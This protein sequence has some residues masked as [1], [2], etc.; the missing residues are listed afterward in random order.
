MES[1]YKHIPQRCEPDD[2]RRCQSAGPHGQCAF[3]SV[4]G[5][6]RC[7][8]HLGGTRTEN[9]VSGRT[10]ELFNIKSIEVI[11]QLQ[12]FKNHPDSKKLTT[13]LA[14]LRVLLENT[15]NQC[16]SSFDLLTH[17]SQIMNLT[18]KIQATLV[19]NTK[20]E[21]KIGDLLSIDQVISIAKALYSAVTERITDPDT[22]E[23]IAGDFQ[24]ILTHDPPKATG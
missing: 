24:R 13:E 10:S 6:D 9:Y 11:N 18:D 5:T 14:L 16:E 7:P 15:L 22:L 19:S 12:K 23:K 1:D 20:L 4:P 2:P 21:E 8:M 17:S 3:L